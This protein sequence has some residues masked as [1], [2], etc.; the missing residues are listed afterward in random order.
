MKRTPL[1]ERVLPVYTKREEIFNMVSHIAGGV[2]GIVATVLC[3]AFAVMHRNVYGVVSGAIFGATMI[4][5]YTMSS[6]YHG[7][8]PKLPGK[9][10]FQVIDHCSIYLLIAGTYTPFSLCTLRPVS[11]VIG[12]SIFGIV[13]GMA[14]LGIVLNSIDLEAFKIFS[15][16][17][18]LGMGWCIV[19][20]A[21]TM[22]QELGGGGTALLLGGGVAYTVGAVFYAFGRRKAYIHSVFHL[23]VCLGSFLH[24][25]CILLYVM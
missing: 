11:P 18:Y 20:A 16:C 14:V 12:W 9:K 13:C 22:I 6:I 4:V 21:G 24:F 8:S 1:R 19:A 17:S 10:V 5:L 2:L 3:V 25:F 15:M 23:F 7:L